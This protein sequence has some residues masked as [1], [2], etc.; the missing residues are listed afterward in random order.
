LGALFNLM[1]WSFPNANAIEQA[2]LQQARK[3]MDEIFAAVARGPMGIKFIERGKTEGMTVGEAKALTLMWKMPFGDV[4][5]D[6]RAVLTQVDA[7]H[8]AACLDAIAVDKSEA[9]LCF[10]LGVA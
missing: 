10:A 5:A 8:L 2:I 3:T 1:Q 7:A 9:D 6:I 4:L